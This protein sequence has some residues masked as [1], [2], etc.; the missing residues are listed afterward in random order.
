MNYENDRSSRNRGRDVLAIMLPSLLVLLVFGIA[1]CIVQREAEAAKAKAAYEAM[2][3]PTATERRSKEI[4]DWMLDAGYDTARIVYSG[5]SSVVEGTFVRGGKIYGVMVEDPTPEPGDD[6]RITIWM[7]SF[8]DRIDEF[9]YV[10]Q[11][12]PT[13]DTVWGAYLSNGTRATST[14]DTAYDNYVSQEVAN[15]Q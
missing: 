10:T 7:G 12:T 1:G 9:T 11:A 13:P 3:E 4:R 5:E 2:H 6:E 15:H 14:P 8:G